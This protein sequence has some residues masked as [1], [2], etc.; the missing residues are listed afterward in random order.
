MRYAVLAGGLL[1][2]FP[3]MAS[4]QDDLVQLKA[5]AM[6]RELTVRKD[7]MADVARGEKEGSESECRN[8]LS[9]GWKVIH[10]PIK[11]IDPKDINKDIKKPNAG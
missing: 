9:K 6:Q 8:Y 11:K 5:A 1:L 10:A 2:S 4:C 7:V 3:A